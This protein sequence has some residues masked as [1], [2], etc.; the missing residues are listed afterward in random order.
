VNENA[1]QLQVVLIL[2]EVQSTP[3]T[4]QVSGTNLSAY[5]EI[6]IHHIC[7]LLRKTQLYL[8]S[9]VKIEKQCAVIKVLALGTAQVQGNIAETFQLCLRH[10]R[11]T[12]VMEF[13]LQP[14]YKV[15]HSS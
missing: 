12:K 6:Y 8:H 15:A 13:T 14:Y 9:L 2:S 1:G 10:I 11:D 3:I 7:D 4:V 5:G